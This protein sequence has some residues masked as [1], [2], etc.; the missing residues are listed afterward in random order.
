M[1]VTRIMHNYPNRGVNYH[2]FQNKGNYPIIP[3]YDGHTIEN[4]NE[5]CW[6][7]PTSLMVLDIIIFP[8]SSLMCCTMVLNRLSGWFVL[9]RSICIQLYLLRKKLVSI[10]ITDMEILTVLM[11][12]KALLMYMKTSLLIYSGIP[13]FLI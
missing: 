4:Y 10:N 6:N 2:I 9:R 11:N 5:H 1:G 12:S 3:I 8:P 7:L 13:Y